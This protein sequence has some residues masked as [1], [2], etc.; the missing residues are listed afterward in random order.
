ME[1]CLLCV[2]R[3]RKFGFVDHFLFVVESG[4]EEK[5]GVFEFADFQE[6]CARPSKCSIVFYSES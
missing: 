4:L 1:L 2:L 5:A 3:L 6:F